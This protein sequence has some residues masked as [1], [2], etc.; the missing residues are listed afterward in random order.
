MPTQRSIIDADIHPTM[1]PAR[2][3]EYLPEPWRSRYASGNRGPG[4]LGYWNAAGFLQA[5]AVTDEGDWIATAP[6]TLSP[7]FFDRHGLEYG[8]LNSE[9]AHPYRGRSGGGVRRRGA[10]GEERRDDPRVAAGR[11]AISRLDQCRAYRTRFSPPQEIRR[12]GDHPR[13]VEVM[14]GSGARIPY[15]N[16]YYHPIYEAAVEFD[17]PVAIHPGNEGVGITGPANAA[18]YPTSYFE[19]HTT[20]VTSYISHLVSLVTEGVFQQFPTLRFVLTEAGVSWLPPILWR[21]D[22]NWMALRKT[23]PWLERKPSE[24]RLRPR[25]D[26]HAADRGAGESAAPEGDAGDVPGRADGDVL[27]RFPALGWRYTR[28]RGAGVPEGATRACDGGTARELYRLPR[29]ARCE[30]EL[31]PMAREPHRSVAG[32][33]VQTRFGPG[34]RKLVTVKRHSVGVFNVNGEY[35]AVL[36]LCPHE[37][38]P[39]CRGPVGGTTLPSKP[40]KW[41]LGPGGRNPL[42]PVAW[43]GIRFA[44]RAVRLPIQEFGCGDTRSRSRMERYT[45]C[46]KVNARRIVA[47]KSPV[48]AARPCVGLRT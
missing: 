48:L 36:N 28:F 9:A 18:G 45:S 22:K 20:L 10:F 46:C 39:V 32:R 41:R 29:R 5:D 24:Y 23:T 34:E 47:F 35:V 42:L 16:R 33:D 37:L 12:I 1:D 14:M 11:R 19:W 38:A 7:Q 44:D 43:L 13:M 2:V 40:G 26:D 27:Q 4:T 8:L 6:E 30:E 15:G 31:A 3:T 17:L 21:L 25:A